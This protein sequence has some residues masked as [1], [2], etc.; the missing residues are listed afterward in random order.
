LYEH[1]LAKPVFQATP[2]E[3]R[4]V[5]PLVQA[6]IA[7]Q[8]TG[9]VFLKSHNV[10]AVR[11]GVP[12]IN[13]A[14][15]AGAVYLVRDPRDVA[16]SL[17]RHTGRSMDF[18]VALLNQPD[19]YAFGQGGSAGETWGSWSQN[20]ESWTT[21]SAAGVV[22]VRYEDMLAQPVTAFGKILSRL[23]YALTP[24]QIA[25]A[26]RFSSFNEMQS[27][28]DRHGFG[29]KATATKRFFGVG[30]SGSWRGRLTPL[31][32]KTIVAAHRPMMKKF[33]YLD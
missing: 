2:A 12:T 33:G 29:E 31:Q 16:V 19:A 5:R 25:E 4:R 6:A 20:V 8:S 32:L 11:D 24:D 26:V 1:F 7:A 22:T 15:L 13:P 9:R 30:K 23:G 18:V 3:C 14:V 21:R 27:Q 10:H 17:Q 28:E